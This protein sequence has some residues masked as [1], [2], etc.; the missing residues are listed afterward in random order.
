MAKRNAG[1]LRKYL[2]GVLRAAIHHIKYTLNKIQ[3]DL[4][5]EQVAHR[6]HEHGSRLLPAS[7]LVNHFVVQANLA[8]P[9]RFRC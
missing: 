2:K 4:F 7:R 8:S 1:A 6:V 9:S 3:G 5:M